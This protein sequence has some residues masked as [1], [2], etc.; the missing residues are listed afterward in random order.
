M[1]K[2]E[3]KDYS[4][5]IDFNPVIHQGLNENHV[6]QQ[7]HPLM[8]IEKVPFELGELKILDVY[9]S[10][11]NSHDESKRTVRFSKEEYEQLMGIERVRPQQLNSFVKALQ[12]KIITI[13]H[14][15]AREGWEN[16]TLFS[17][18]SCRKDEYEQWWVSLTCTEE[19]RN[20]FFNNEKLGYI[21]YYLSNILPLTSKY[22]IFLYKYLLFN[23][24][25][26]KWQVSVDELRET[27]FRCNSEYYK[28]FKRFK[29]EIL[30]KTLAE[31]ND[32]TDLTFNISTTAKGCKL[33]RIVKNIEFTLVKDELEVK[34]LSL[35]VEPLTDEDKEAKYANHLKFIAGACDYEFDN[36][37]MQMILSAV[38]NIPTDGDKHYQDLQRYNFVMDC[39]RTMNHYDKKKKPIKKANRFSYLRNIIK[40]KIKQEYNIDA[41][42]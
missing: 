10:R 12:S 16:F 14:R 40:N 1:P 2:A 39:Y 18:S 34:Q 11:I 37:E 32:K 17:G 30:N 27:V 23:R 21:R 20:L 41:N 15:Y 8:L 5:S 38:L 7:S 22:S 42:L 26:V 4:K 31:V 13:P 24:I 25:R 19:A 28:E 35:N 29:N 6:V 9:L 36:D 3:I 33:G